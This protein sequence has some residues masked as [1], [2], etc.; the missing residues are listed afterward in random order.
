MLPM[1]W[2]YKRSRYFNPEAK[3]LVSAITPNWVFSVI[4]AIFGIKE[5]RFIRF[6]EA[7]SVVYC[8]KIIV[9]SLMRASP[10]ISSDYNFFTDDVVRI[11]SRIVD[12]SVSEQKRIYISRGG[13]APTA[14][15]KRYLVGEEQVEKCVKDRG[16]A[17]VRPELM[18]WPQQVC[19]F[20]RAETVM[21]EFGSGLHNTVFSPRSTL[22]I[23]LSNSMMS[24]TQ[25]AIAAMRGQPLQYIKPT[26]EIREGSRIDCTYDVTVIGRCLDEL[27]GVR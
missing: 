24:W 14:S 7:N 25:S 11:C 23:V 18:S 10:Y 1:I 12:L 3:F 17:I 27:L 5:D 9:P 15:I 21:G 13:I 20:A 22:N 16:F 19:M 2:L 8:R 6:S 26:S 4:D